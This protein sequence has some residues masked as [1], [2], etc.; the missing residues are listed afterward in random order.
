MSLFRWIPVFVA[1][2]E[3]AGGPSRRMNPFLESL[4]GRALLSSFGTTPS[5]PTGA[6]AVVSKA[7]PTSQLSNPP[8]AAPGGSLF[9]AADDPL[10][11]PEPSPG[12]YPGSNPP[13]DHPELPPSGAVGPGS[14]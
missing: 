9:I 14:S 5:L 12:P 13:I 11:N 4:E 8:T 2:S 6:P 1:R 7:S 3:P 10:P